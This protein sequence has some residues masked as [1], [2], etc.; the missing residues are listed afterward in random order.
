MITEVA[1][2]LQDVPSAHREAG[3]SPPCGSFSTPAASNE[4]GLCKPG[5]GF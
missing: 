4:A 1:P 5:D 3:I 2:K